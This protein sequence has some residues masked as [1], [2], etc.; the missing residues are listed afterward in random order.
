[1]SRGNYESK[2][3]DRR[4]TSGTPRILSVLGIVGD[5][6]ILGVAVECADIERNTDSEGGH[7]DLYR[8]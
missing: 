5:D 4:S 8:R 7:L 3:K 2:V 6:G 1:M